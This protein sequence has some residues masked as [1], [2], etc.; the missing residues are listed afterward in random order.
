MRIS[1]ISSSF[2]SVVIRVIDCVAVAGIAVRTFLHLTSTR[3]PMGYWLE[4]CQP[5]FTLGGYHPM[6]NPR[7]G[8]KQPGPLRLLGISVPAV[9]PA[10][11]AAMAAANR[12]ASAKPRS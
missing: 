11:Q 3:E 7:P 10:P 12:F 5:G 4:P 8:Y 2:A 9:C 1:T 6:G